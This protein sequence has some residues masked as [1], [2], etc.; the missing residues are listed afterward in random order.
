M[1]LF[2]NRDR[3]FSEGWIAQR[4][5]NRVSEIVSVKDDA[6]AS[7]T[8]NQIAL[9]FVNRDI[10]KFSEISKGQ[11]GGVPSIESNRGN[12]GMLKQRL[13]NGHAQRRRMRG[14]VGMRLHEVR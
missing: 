1:N 4:N 3:R 7:P 11:S 6:A 12:G 14:G 13:V 8:A 9:R 2:V 5:Y 10:A